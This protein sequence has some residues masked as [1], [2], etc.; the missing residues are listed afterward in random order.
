M[1]DVTISVQQGSMAKGEQNA[2]GIGQTPTDNSVP[3]H[4]APPSN[5]LSP[6]LLQGF[7]PEAEGCG[8]HVRKLSA[9]V[10][11]IQEG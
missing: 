6:D 7:E 5:I 4:T 1:F 10:C 11:E 2:P 8:Q 9:Y 3:T